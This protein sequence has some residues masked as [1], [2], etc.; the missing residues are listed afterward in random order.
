MLTSKQTYSSSL[1]RS[2]TQPM[3]SSKPNLPQSETLLCSFPLPY[4]LE[5]SQNL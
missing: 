2:E 5:E 1:P 4:K 3:T